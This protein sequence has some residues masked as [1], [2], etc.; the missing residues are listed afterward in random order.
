MG[1]CHKQVS[2]ASLSFFGVSLLAHALVLVGAELY[3]RSDKTPAKTPAGLQSALSGAA[4]ILRHTLDIQE[5]RRALVNE[6]RQRLQRKEPFRLGEFLL[7]SNRIDANALHISFDEEEAKLRYESRLLALRDELAHSDARHAVAQVFG[8]L[9]YYG[10]PGGLMGN[11]LLERGG[12]CEQ[13]AQL[14]SAALYDTG[15]GKDAGM[16]FYGG[17]MADGTVH[18]S[19]TF[20]VDKTEYDLMSGKTAIQQGIHLNP[21]DWVEI[22]ARAHGLAQTQTPP[23][24]ALQEI[25]GTSS[26]QKNIKNIQSPTLSGMAD[27]P[28]LLAGLPPNSDKYPGALPL[29]AS[30]AI[31]RPDTSEGAASADMGEG[32]SLADRA[33]DCA[34]FVRMAMLNPPR[35]EIQAPRDSANKFHRFD[36]EPFRIPTPARLEREALL[37]KGAEELAYGGGNDLAD[38]LMGLSCLAGLGDMAAVDFSLAGEHSLSGLA[39]EQKKEA[40]KEGARL[41]S[42]INWE[43]SE[44]FLIRRRFS[45]EYGGRAWL[46][47]ALPG[48]DEVVFQMA[49]GGKTDDWGRVSALSAL[50]LWPKTQRRA[51]GFLET[52]AMRDQVEVMHEVFHA[53]DH[54]R[55]W[56]SNFDLGEAYMAAE[57]GAEPEQSQ[58]IKVYRV[59]RGMA[60]RL[61]EGQREVGEILP[62]LE[63]ESEAAGIDQ[64]WRAGL[65]MYLT[66]NALGLFSQR[67]NG[68]EAVG[69][70]KDAVIRNAHPSLDL[71]KTQLVY[72]ESQGRLNARTLADALRME[73]PDP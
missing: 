40:E 25:G 15:L 17:A 49:R 34:Y 10:K 47:L 16:R 56:A 2:R 63:R 59:F 29:Y 60:F 13:M 44:G 20:T 31:Q 24:K 18:I 41:I 66:R 48:G 71:L 3:P 7:Q 19:P 45:S 73:R 58:F 26:P 50:V 62:E 67:A 54:M 4:Q 28:S 27:R 69:I 30:N 65:L 43:G 68:F 51:I 1:Y 38:R 9:K 46:M 35:V 14:V 57:P 70:L 52:L 36:I 22:Y 64:A 12:S 53:H 11:A 55:P 39:I 61:W 8:D 33:R 42:A 32:L 72:I 6:A 5:E 23:P 21:E 37:L